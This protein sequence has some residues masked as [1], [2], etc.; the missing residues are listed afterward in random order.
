MR[1]TLKIMLLGL[2]LL[3]SCKRTRSADAPP[4]EGPGRTSN[5]PPAMSTSAPAATQPTPPGRAVAAPTGGVIIQDGGT[6]APG[7]R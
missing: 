4:A 3:P 1:V 5:P 6:G 2:L 7:T